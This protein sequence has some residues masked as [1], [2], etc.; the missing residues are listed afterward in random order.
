NCCVAFSKGTLARYPRC[1]VRNDK[2]LP[3]NARSP[4][5]RRKHSVLAVV[6]VRP[7]TSPQFKRNETESA[8]WLEQPTIIGSIKTHRVVTRLSTAVRAQRRA[9]ACRWP[10]GVLA[11]RLA[12]NSVN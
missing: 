9:C 1:I 2:F 11:R 10:P 12:A 7:N 3:P 4:L 8:D 6:A 5:P